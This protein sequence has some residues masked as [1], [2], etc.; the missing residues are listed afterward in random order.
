MIAFLLLGQAGFVD[1][2][3]EYEGAPNKYIVYVPPAYDKAKALPAIMF[4]HGAGETGTDGKKQAEVGLGAAI[5]KSP[6]AWNFIVMFPQKPPGKTGWVNHEK[7]V[8]DMLEK[9]KKEYS[10][11]NARIYLTGLSMGGYG[12]W[13]IAPKHPEIFAAIAPIC[14]GGNPDD[15]PKLKDMPT[16]CFHGD[17]D[18]AVPIAKSQQMIDAIK[19]AGGEP[20]FTIYPGVGHN[21][22]DKAYREE[23]LNEWLLQF[24]KK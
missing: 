4:L 20:K 23:K 17:A 13:Q 2:T 7:L 12:T 9:T 16:W 22:W 10:I 19:K 21:S 24:K 6:E 15:A 1:K 18:K 3:I 11:D 14:G 8:L 5:K